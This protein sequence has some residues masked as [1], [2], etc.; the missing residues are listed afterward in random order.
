MRFKKVSHCMEFSKYIRGH[1]GR[2]LRG[3]RDGPAERQGLLD[4]VNRTTS[5]NRANDSDLSAI[6]L[7][8]VMMYALH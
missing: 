6:M 4:V 1:R 3:D 7:E 5:D 2:R 8:L